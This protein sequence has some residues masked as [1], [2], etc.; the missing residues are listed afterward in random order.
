[1]Q[2]V[3]GRVLHL[4][5]IWLL[6]L[7]FLTVDLNKSPEEQVE[8]G[9]GFIDAQNYKKV[10]AIAT[11]KGST[12]RGSMEIVHNTCCI[13][14]KPT[15]AEGLREH[16]SRLK[17]RVTREAFR[18]RCE[19]EAAQEHM[20]SLVLDAPLP[21]HVDQQQISLNIEKSYRDIVE[22]TES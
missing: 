22:K 17:M 3:F 7:V 11:P 8:L 13:I 16:D 5:L 14:L 1:V 15:A 9:K 19:K 12:R 21:V 6:I 4:L 10:L 20:D 2:K 18:Q